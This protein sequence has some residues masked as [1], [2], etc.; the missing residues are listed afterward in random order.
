MIAYLC[1]RVAGLVALL[2]AISILVF[3]IIRLIPGNPALVILGTAGGNP[4][5]VARLDHQLGLDAAGKTHEAS[6]AGGVS[7]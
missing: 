6:E 4:A 2:I 1:K 3:M 7:T 5:T